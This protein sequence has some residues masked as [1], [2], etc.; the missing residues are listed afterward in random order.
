MAKAFACILA[1]LLIAAA[2]APAVKSL[3]IYAGGDG[4]STLHLHGEAARQ[5]LAITGIYDSGAQRDLTHVAKYHC[6]SPVIKVDRDGLVTA[7]KNGSATISIRVSDAGDASAIASQSLSVTVD[8]VGETIPIN[9][10]NQVVP[11]FTK[12]GCNAGGCH[13]K[14]SGQNGFRLSLLGFEPAE[15]YEHLVKEA[16]GRRLFPAAPERSLLLLKATAA[17]P[18]GGGKRLNIDSDEYR[19]LVRWISQG[20]PFGSPA[21]PS[22]KSIDVFPAARIMERGGRQQLI[23]TARYTDGSTEDVTRQALYEANEKEMAAA[24]EGGV[25]SVNQQPGDVAVMVRYQGMVATFRATLPLGAPMGTLPPARNFIDDLVFKK[26][27]QIGMPPSGVCSDQT[28]LRRVT[29]D[30]AGRMPSEKEMADFLADKDSGRRDKCIDRLLASNDY[31]DFFAN[32]WSALLRNRRARPTY[33][34]GTYA[35]HDWIRDSLLTNK[36]YDQFV[37]EIIS[38]SGDIA[39]NPAVGWYREV[40]D[41]NQQLEDVAQLFMGMRI[42]CA[43]CH[44]HPFEKWSQQDYYS[45]SAFFS[46]EG[47]KA[48]NETGQEIVYHQRGIPSAVNPKN[49]QSVKPAGPGSAP[50][51]LPPDVDPRQAL[52]SWMTAR[53]NP[54]FARSLVNRYWKHFLGRGIVEPEDDLRETNPPTNPELLDALSR[55]FAGSGYDLKALVRTICQ[56]TTYQLDA[57]PNQYNGIDRQ[58]FSRYYPKRLEAEVLLDAVDHL[59]G[60]PTRFEGMPAGTRAVQL[61]DNSFNSSVYFLTVFGRPDSSSA[62][63]CER[64]D[65]PNLAQ[66]L[67]LLNAQ[68]IQQKLASPGGRAAR[69]AADTQQPDDV[70]LRGLYHLAYTREPDISELAAAKGYIEQALSKSKDKDKAATRKR[71]YEDILWALIN[72][73]EFSFNH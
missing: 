29:L 22:V 49:H 5:Q 52:A 12:L 32:T 33:A 23:V 55:Y 15:D 60:V 58:N 7:L 35:F 37:R 31:A 17:L 30:V 57:T 69:L 18:H 70:H 73:K 64:S 39:D 71:A 2:P 27:K 16:R 10:P 1:L 6:D 24:G 65:A 13:G 56:S 48:N 11:I 46:R 41:P 59:T 61:P 51:D 54:F 20:I 40:K 63:E 68:G 4:A 42:H 38:A 8:R 19:L 47:R 21:D 53:E 28:F 66:C 45:F 62:C 9:F 50:L 72:S 14:L 34:A 3:V 43:Q 26:L 67:H 25:V 36:P 44:H